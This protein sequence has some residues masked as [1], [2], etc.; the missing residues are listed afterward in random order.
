MIVQ[1]AFQ[2]MP[3]KIPDRTMARILA[4]SDFYSDEDL[5]V[6]WGIS[7]RTIVRYRQRASVDPKLA[8]IVTECRKDLQD[9]W[10]ENALANLNSALIELKRRYTTARSK[11]DA[12]CIQAIA[13]ALKIVGELKIASD[14]LS[15]TDTETFP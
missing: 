11:D 3:T 2:P 7:R 14:A 13:S 5:S 4:E 15:D 10:V 12:E 9:V 8:S 6:R 1:P